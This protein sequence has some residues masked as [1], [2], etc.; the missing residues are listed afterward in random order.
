MLFGNFILRTN[1]D[2]ERAALYRSNFCPKQKRSLM[3]MIENGG[4]EG[5]LKSEPSSANASLIL[6][7]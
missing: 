4:K 7:I 1:Y 6:E 2:V 3:V 5:G